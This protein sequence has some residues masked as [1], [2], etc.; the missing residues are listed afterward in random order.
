MHGVCTAAC[1]AAHSCASGG[2][3]SSVCTHRSAPRADN[4]RPSD[5][6]GTPSSS[7]SS[8]RA[9][10]PTESAASA[11]LDCAVA[12]STAA[13]ASRCQGSQ[14]G[15]E[16]KLLCTLLPPAT[17]NSSH[18]QRLNQTTYLARAVEVERAQAAPHGGEGRQRAVL[19]QQPRRH[20]ADLLRLLARRARIASGTATQ[21]ARRNGSPARRAA[22]PA[23]ATA[24]HRRRALP[25]PRPR[26][27]RRGCRG[28]RALSQLKRQPTATAAA[29]LREDGAVRHGARA[30][31]PQLPAPEASRDV[32]AAPARPC[33]PSIFLD[34]KN[35]RGTGNSQS[36]WTDSKMETAG[37]PVDL[38]RAVQPQ[39]QSRCLVPAA[40]V[41]V[42]AGQHQV[43]G[44]VLD[45]RGRLARQPRRR[46]GPLAPTRAAPP[47]GRRRRRAR[48]RQQKEPLGTLR[49]KRLLIESRWVPTPLAFAG[50]RRPRRPNNSTF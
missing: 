48:A 45:L 22:P 12:L 13:R 33:S 1:S 23:S 7:P 38:A 16:I 25:H 5:G 39:P 37:A 17:T 50:T 10:P 34:R 2:A 24:P 42:S 11:R 40:R 49:S 31:S 20:R 9:L 36:I 19:R 47:C 43:V 29:H 6:A 8:C 15:A 27:R 28:T 30:R 35:R 26:R 44:R 4:G 46:R 3:P 41:V 14:P 18:P 32:I 21:C